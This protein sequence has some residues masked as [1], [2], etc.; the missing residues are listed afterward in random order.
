[1]Q[2]CFG[3][4]VRQTVV[5]NHDS[6]VIRIGKLSGLKLETASGELLPIPAKAHVAQAQAYAD[7]FAQ[8]IIAVH[9]Y[10]GPGQLCL[11]QLAYRT[12]DVRLRCCGVHYSSGS[13]TEPVPAIVSITEPQPCQVS[14]FVYAMYCEQYTYELQ[15]VSC[16]DC[17][18]FTVSSVAV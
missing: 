2:V 11:H 16:Q 4:R 5:E 18:S 12:A 14:R 17:L 9:Q 3:D 10:Y 1:M 6:T 13:S 7:A 8:G 15:N